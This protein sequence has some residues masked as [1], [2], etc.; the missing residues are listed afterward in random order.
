V[1]S[2][3]ID[4]MDGDRVLAALRPSH[5][6]PDPAWSEHELA[7]IM[8][9]QTTPGRRS[10]RRRV[11]VPLV[12][13][14]ALAA[15]AGV[16]YAAGLVPSIITDRLDDAGSDPLGRVGPSRLLLD[17]RL[18]DGTHLQIWR[19]DNAAGGECEVVTKNLAAG[20]HPGDFGLTCWAGPPARTSSIGILRPE[21]SDYNDLPVLYGERPED[22]T[23]ATSVH[24]SGPGVDTTL[25]IG[26]KNGGFGRELPPTRRGV[27]FIVTYLDT[28]GHDLRTE[29]I[30]Y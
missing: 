28:S 1:H 10:I 20:A 2:T 29:Q 17:M 25:E 14:I 24:I 27:T 5:T 21:D 18:S 11:L 12:V 22:L 8:A 7:R 6:D 30:T 16:A 19:A 9:D 3:E 15:T 13:G 26:R 23:R 4:P